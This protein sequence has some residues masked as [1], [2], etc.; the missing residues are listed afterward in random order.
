MHGGVTA[1]VEGPPLHTSIILAIADSKPEDI[2][3]R[4]EAGVVNLSQGG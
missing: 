1:N 2:A 4:T 3:T